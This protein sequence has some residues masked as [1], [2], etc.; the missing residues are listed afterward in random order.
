MYCFDCRLNL[1]HMTEKGKT[2]HRP[3]SRHLFPDVVSFALRGNPSF[4]P[5]R[6]NVQRALLSRAV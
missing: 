3:H 5:G 2:T 1:D 4:R 6:V